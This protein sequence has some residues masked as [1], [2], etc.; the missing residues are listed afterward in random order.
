[1]TKHYHSGFDYFYPDAGK[2][3]EMKCQAC[4]QVMDVSRNVKKTHGRY[5]PLKKNRIV[6]AFTCLSS[7][8]DW[9]N[10]VIEL[11]KYSS[12]IPS[13]KLSNIV[14]EEIAEILSI[15]ITS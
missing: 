14:D 12:S 2:E 1:M 8:T 3:K 5:G 9:H 10:Q 7:G 13:R 15:Y 11:R 6:D 4:F